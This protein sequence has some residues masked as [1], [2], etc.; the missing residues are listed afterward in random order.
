MKTRLTK[1][2]I[3]GL[4]DGG[5]ASGREYEGVVAHPTPSKVAI[6]KVARKG[7]NWDWKLS[8]SS[9]KR[10]SKEIYH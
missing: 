1:E 3:V 2:V 6:K 8:L 4:F 10:Q 7:A 5:K 9:Q